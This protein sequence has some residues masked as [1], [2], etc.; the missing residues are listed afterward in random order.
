VFM[1]PLGI[2]YAVAILGVQS[3]PRTV[4]VGALLLVASG[5]WMAYSVLRGSSAEKAVGVGAQPRVQ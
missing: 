5:A 1:Y 3:T 2:V 4:L